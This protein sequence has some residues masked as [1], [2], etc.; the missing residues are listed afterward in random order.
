VPIQRYLVY[1]E[2]PD[3]SPGVKADK[4]NK[5]LKKSI[6]KSRATFIDIMPAFCS[7]GCDDIKGVEVCCAARDSLPLYRDVSHLTRHANKLLFPIIAPY[8]L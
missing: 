5:F 7:A 1:L 4:I 8:F 6:K 3:W 2:G